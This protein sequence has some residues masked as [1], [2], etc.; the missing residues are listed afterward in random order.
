VPTVRLDREPRL[1][2][3][4]ARAA[5]TARGRGGSS[6]PDTEVERLGVVV[7]RARL[8]DYDRVCGYAVGDAVPA[9][10]LHVLSFPL[11]VTVMAQRGFP[12]ALPGLVHVAGVLVQHRRVG[13]EEP[14]DLRVR[15]EGLRPHPRGRQVDLVA[16]AAV[17]G[18]PVWSGRSTYLARGAGGAGPSDPAAQAVADEGSAAVAAA[19]FATDADEGSAAVADE[20]PWDADVLA[21][22]APAARWLVP[23]DTGRRYAAVSG[24]VNP[25]H[26]AAPA[27]RAFGFPRALAHGMWTAARCLSS[28]QPR[29]PPS[30]EVRLAFGRPVLLPSTVELRTRRQDGG[31]L[32][33]VGSR[34]GGEHLR[35]LLLDR[36]GR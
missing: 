33:G 31:W 23:A 9:T 36:S 13:A 25:I 6:L 20:V 7:D 21:G 14:L 12:L 22:A 18:E 24:D 11:Q 1:P 29:T 3:L 2:L 19:A 26:L 30:F 35:G 8:A 5:L 4:L 27:A 28:L 16:T 15:A 10:F 32:F 17:A 34:S